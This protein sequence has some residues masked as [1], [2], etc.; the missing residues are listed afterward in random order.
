MKIR[1][2][3]KG[4]ILLF[5]ILGIIVLGSGGYLL[6][7]V[8]QP[9]TIAPTDSD[10]VGGNGSCCI[11][12]IGCS[13]GYTCKD[14]DCYDCENPYVGGYGESCGT[15]SSGASVNCRSSFVCDSSKSSLKCCP[16]P[17][18]ANPLWTCVEDWR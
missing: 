4:K 7:R 12:S 17:D 3:K 10:A 13:A 5:V 1:I 11:E 14:I 18:L 16:D 6:W 8:L 9:D 15:N 2:T